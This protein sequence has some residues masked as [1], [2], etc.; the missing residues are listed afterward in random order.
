MTTKH[1]YWGLEVA[2]IEIGEIIGVVNIYLLQ[3]GSR[4]ARARTSNSMG[5]GP[6][7]MLFS[8]E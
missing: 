5:T 8:L 1:A 6:G 3:N 4:M 2:D 7:C